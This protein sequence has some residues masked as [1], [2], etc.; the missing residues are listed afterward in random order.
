MKL[1]FPFGRPAPSRV[2]LNDVLLLYFLAALIFF[3]IATTQN[4]LFPGDLVFWARDYALLT[5]CLGGNSEACRQISK[6][7]L[8]Y[9][10][11]SFLLGL[12]PF[13]GIPYSSLLAALNS[14]ALSLPILLLRSIQNTRFL[15]IAWGLYVVVWILTPIPRFYLLSG[16]LEVQAGALI[17]MAFVLTLR[18]LGTEFDRAKPGNGITM[19]NLLLANGLWFMAC[20]FKDTSVVTF[21]FAGLL[22]LIPT[23]SWLARLQGQFGKQNKVSE[24]KKEHENFFSSYRL[25]AL[26]LTLPGFAA[27]AIA[28]MLFNFI[29]YQNVMPMAY[30]NEAK[31][32]ATPPLFRLQS[33]F[34]SFLSPNG[35]MLVF[36]G[37]GFAC[38][39][40]YGLWF[41]LHHRDVFLTIKAPIVWTAITLVGL[42]MWWNPFGW[43]SWGNRL[44][45][46]SIMAVLI[47]YWESL[48]RVGFAEVTIAGSA[49]PVAHSFM[50]NETRHKHPWRIKRLAS[51]LLLIAVA[52]LFSAKYVRFGYIANP[53][54]ILWL[55]APELAYCAKM[56]SILDVT[57]EK[58]HLE[59]VY[60]TKLWRQCA[61]EGYRYNPVG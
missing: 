30:L 11:N 13:Q 20:L 56:R 10:L 44:I 58:L 51:G 12:A 5:H 47:C 45:M 7:P 15:L 40:F 61:L 57:P 53:T 21:A 34:W 38:L 37:L 23:K 16:S 33:L 26:G 27:A 46:P 22:L 6:F 42:S 31:I 18:I 9:T 52:V 43:A 14:F 54:L 41:R 25:R 39:F 59:R 49:L 28:Q 8:G 4:Q 24:V 3:V 48:I 32:T 36:W 17:A 29:R 60:G 19:V 35:G 55:P 1:E 50:P 2:G